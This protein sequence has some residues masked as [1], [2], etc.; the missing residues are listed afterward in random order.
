MRTHTQTS[1]D[2]QQGYSERQLE[3]LCLI[4]R[5]LHRIEAKLG[6]TTESNKVIAFDER[7]RR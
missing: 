6:T 1:E 7:W 2:A 4:A 3:L 5:A